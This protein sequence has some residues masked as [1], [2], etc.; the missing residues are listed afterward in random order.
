M[1]QKRCSSYAMKSFF[2][3]FRKKKPQVPFE[4]FY[5]TYAHKLWGL[6][7][8]ANLP[9]SESETILINTL[10]KAWLHPDR[11]VYIDRHP[12]IWLLQ[13]AYAEGLPANLL[14]PILKANR[15]FVSL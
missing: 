9:A 14:R 2:K 4:T 13:L 5:N 11:Q 8:I 10:T 1:V 3:Q 15:V 12:C 7:L 6:I